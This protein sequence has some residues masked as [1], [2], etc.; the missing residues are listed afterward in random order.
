MSWDTPGND[1]FDI[2]PLLFEFPYISR[3]IWIDHTHRSGVEIL[4]FTGKKAGEGQ[5]ESSLIEFLTDLKKK[6]G[7]E[8][9]LIRANTRSL[10]QN[11]LWSIFH[12][13][14]PID[15]NV[16]QQNPFVPDFREYISDLYTLL[17]TFKN[18]ILPLNY[19]TN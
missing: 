10:I 11:H 18:I 2:S 16:L 14:S 15:L 6:Q 17:I 8:T 5:E 12:K 7:F 9:I 1:D 19:T 13:D 3:L 4:K